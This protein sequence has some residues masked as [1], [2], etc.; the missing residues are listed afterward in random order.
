MA[1]AGLGGLA[2]LA[3]MPVSGVA[4]HVPCAPG[5]CRDPAPAHGLQSRP[6]AMPAPMFA[7]DPA[8]RA[9]ARLVA[10]A[11]GKADTLPRPGD[12]RQ[13]AC[14]PGC[15]VGLAAW[16]MPGGEQ[17]ARAVSRRA[18]NDREEGPGPASADLP[19]APRNGL[20][21][22][23]EIAT[24]D[25]RRFTVGG[26]GL[27]GG[28]MLPG[29]SLPRDGF[30][31]AGRP[32]HAGRPDGP[33][34]SVLFPA[35]T[36]A[37]LALDETGARA[38][39]PGG[40]PGCPDVA[41]P[42]IAGVLQCGS[43]SQPA[44]RQ[45]DGPGD[46]VHAGL[47][48][49]VRIQPARADATAAQP[50]RWR[51]ARGD[52][53]S[54]M[55]PAHASAAQTLA[56]PVGRAVLLTAPGPLFT[57]GPGPTPGPTPGP[58]LGP[59]LGPG[60]S[61][62]PGAP[63][64]RLPQGQAA[65]FGRDP[66]R[67]VATAA[68]GSS[69]PQGA[70][71]ER[72]LPGRSRVLPLPAF[73]LPDEREGDRGQ[74]HLAGEGG[75]GSDRAG[76]PAGAAEAGGGTGVLPFA[77]DDELILEFQ[78]GQ[79]EIS[80][81]I[82]AYGNRSA[83]YLPLGEIARLLDLAVSV[84]DEG[85]YASGW[86][87]DEARV[88]SLNLREGKLFLAGSE[89]ALRAADARALDG[90]LYLRSELFE[91]LMPLSLQVNLRAQ[92]VTVRTRAAFPFEQRAARE[93]ARERL[94]LQRPGNRKDGYE[95]EET[96]Y[97]ALDIP[98]GEVEGRGVSDSTRGMRAESD[99]RLA[100]DLAYMTG[101]IYL[102]AST[103]DGL[104]AARM[105]L[106]RRDI[107]NGLLG[108]L[109]ASVFEIGDVASD[110]LAIGLRGLAGRG[111]ALSNAPLERAS[112]FDRIDLRGELPAGW[113]AEI[114]RNNTLVGSTSTAVNGR[115]EF[116]QIPVEFGLN[117]F[118]V[119]LFG[120]QGQRRET[121]RRVSVGD[122]RLAPGE[123]R[124]NLSIVQRDTNV[125]GL[126][127]PDF[128]P[129]LDYGRWRA[130][131]QVAWG[132]SRAITGSLGGGW[133]DSDAGRRWLATAGLR[134][135]LGGVAGQFN[136]GMNDQKGLAFD[137]RLA[138]RNWGI[139][140]TALHA[141]YTGAFSDELRSF[142]AERLRRA[143]EADFV[144]TLRFGSGES[145]FA[146]PFA[147]RVRRIEYADRKVQVE[148]SLRGSAAVSGLLLSNT[149]TLARTTIPGVATTSQALGSFDLA[150]LSSARTRYRASLGYTIAP[151]PRL[152]RAGLEV[153]RT[154]GPDTQVKASAGRIFETRETVLGASAVHRI[155][156]VALAID[157]SVTLPRK[158][159]AVMLRVGFSFGRNPVTRGFFMAPPG[160]SAGGGVAVAAYVD[161]NG[162]RERDEGEPVVEG[163]EIDTGTQVA[164]TGR[165]GV[166]LL[167]QLASATRT[168]VR[169]NA[170]SLPDIAM[171][172]SRTGFEVAPRPG[173]IHVSQF[174]IDMLGEIEG[175]AVFGPER[176]GVSGLVLLLRDKA[177]RDVA[178]TRTGTGGAFLFEQVRPGRY[179][180]VVDKD[181]A[182][183]LELVVPEPVIVDLGAGQSVP[184]VIV[185]VSGQKRP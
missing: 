13:G 123:I 124:Y 37:R 38:A 139:A 70:S 28:Q 31:Q 11:A 102:S 184:R 108:P 128:V 109:R 45:H 129:G 23:I 29:A 81:A 183:R 125:L 182:R 106:G 22:P 61:P 105:T 66:A 180:L 94:A 126:A 86:I 20:V 117:V 27:R 43:G 142:T 40:A 165:D 89:I 172:P 64:G 178:R 168:F 113:E 53:S 56:L 34:Q 103:R 161:A 46:L 174:A 72:T 76:P 49:G 44:V 79:G 18:R 181:Q 42:P 170:E 15:T 160:L 104:T 91:Q 140:W 127:G 148:G 55:A 16:R 164:R 119:A 83:T 157:G 138:G 9:P 146:L 57:R 5:A 93:S 30:V 26:A 99:V 69:A 67:L 36:I 41:G 171:A 10:G 149:L 73:G 116:L 121:V 135:G 21:G 100:G 35:G 185:S 101:Q 144:A 65:G 12:L 84:S 137:T 169:L 145:A 50:A 24:F 74:A 63:S 131:G 14:D 32:S 51:G 1:R 163:A 173:R 77:A 156:P 175:T 58:A 80:Q 134:T 114:Y 47:W 112:V 2:G 33:A 8:D 143:S 107:E 133:Y 71:H 48:Q 59:A 130:S 88:V 98:M 162:N 166:A 176:R 110:A 75:A 111:V 92:T 167:G 153:D 158:E 177:G 154:F 96:A 150:T 141:E 7:K 17:P 136:F 155:G 87:L 85:R 78:T 95:R 97:R 6:P 122:G 39:L 54:G 4:A 159:H 82:T 152:S 132:L 118:R 60:Q 120:P 25:L 68:T 179:A 147:A 3:G 90:E 62:P 19:G 151:A 115:Y 52:L